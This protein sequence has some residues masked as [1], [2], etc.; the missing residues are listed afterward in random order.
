MTDE[1][2]KRVLAE[3]AAARRGGQR[4]EAEKLI[5]VQ[6]RTIAILKGHI[7]TL[8]RSIAML[9]STVANQREIIDITRRELATYRRM[10][11]G[12]LGST[13]GSPVEEQPTVTPS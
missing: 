3:L 10:A 7:E 1:Q 12:I 2:Y 11:D 8:E 5:E 4:P 9:Q 13:P 6:E